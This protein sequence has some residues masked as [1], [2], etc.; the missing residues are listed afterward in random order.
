MV[1]IYTLEVKEPWVMPNIL[2][3]HSVPVHS[4][5]WRSVANCEAK[6]PLI[7]VQKSMTEEGLETRIECREINRA[8]SG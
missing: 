5:R 1:K 4:C 3:N 8:G 6:E 7:E 2:G